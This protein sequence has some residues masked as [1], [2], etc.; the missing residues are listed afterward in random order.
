MNKS[1]SFLVV[2]LL[3]CFCSISFAGNFEDG[4]A[5]Y[6][7]EDYK[8]AHSLFLIEAEKGD[9]VAQ[10][11]LGLIYEHGD[12]VQYDY[13][14][15]AKWYRMAAEQGYARAQHNIGNMYYK[16]IGVVQNNEDAYAWWAVAAAN[17]YVR[18]KNDIEMAKTIFTPAQIE[19]GQ[20]IAKEIWARI[21]N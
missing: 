5:A 10:Y 2:A 20:Q 13:K 12:G 18:A 11:Y 3:F 21:G 19:K 14:V 15:A 17:G 9:A 1:V 8:T 7:A 4:L 6:K 16:G